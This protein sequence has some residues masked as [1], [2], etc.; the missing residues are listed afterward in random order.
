MSCR[1]RREAKGLHQR[2]EAEQQLVVRL[3]GEAEAQQEAARQAVG[4]VERERDA[5]SEKLEGVTAQLEER[6]RWAPGA[7]ELLSSPSPMLPHVR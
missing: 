3:R 1:A 4:A 2:L 5:V 6:A 7:P